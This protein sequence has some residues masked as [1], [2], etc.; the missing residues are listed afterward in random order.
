MPPTAADYG[1]V[2]SVVAP[3]DLEAETRTL[4]ARI[5][6]KSALTIAIGKEAAGYKQIEAGF[7]DA[8]RTASEAM[9]R[10]MLARMTPA[11]AS[12]HSAR[13]ASSR[14]GK[15]AE[16]KRP[17]ARI[18][19][20]SGLHQGEG[21]SSQIEAGSS[22]GLGREGP[23]RGATCSRGTPARRRRLSREPP[24]RR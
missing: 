5:A 20:K 16:A 19:P 14:A 1:L 8:Y 17:S 4:A 9:T 6:G 11:K 24:G 22:R 2:N 7:A 10:N 18:R 3:E 23:Y 13:K 15:T 21:N 12:T